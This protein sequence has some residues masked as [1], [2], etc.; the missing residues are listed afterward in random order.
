MQQ[1]MQPIQAAAPLEVGRNRAVVVWDS[2]RIVVDA[3]TG[4]LKV[5]SIG[6]ALQMILDA[7]KR[8]SERAPGQADYEA[9][10]LDDGEGDEER[11]EREP[12]TAMR[13]S[14]GRY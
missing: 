3:G 1:P 5:E 11:P 13:A 4:P 12:T 6:E 7:Y 9:A 8:S 10:F 2:G 14:A